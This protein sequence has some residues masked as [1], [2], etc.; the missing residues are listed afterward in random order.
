MSTTVTRKGQ[1][2]IPKRV[3]DH[4]GIGPGSEVTFRLAD[5]GSIVVEKRT[6]R[7]SRAV[8]QSWLESPDRVRPPMRSWK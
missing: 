2:T 6:A 4:L 5:D 1:A 7:G 3:R 8:S